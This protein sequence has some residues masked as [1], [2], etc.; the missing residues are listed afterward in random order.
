M[1]N[2]ITLEKILNVPAIALL[3]TGSSDQYA[4]LKNLPYRHYVLCLDGDKS[5][6]LGASKLIKA[7]RNTHI[8]TV[9]KIKEE[10]KL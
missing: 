8:L 1:L 7:L 10:G 5:G 6:F 2:A 9:Y 4:I 3:G